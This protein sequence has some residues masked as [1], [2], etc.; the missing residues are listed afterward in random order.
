MPE[1]DGVEATAEIRRLKHGAN[2]PII[3]CTAHA[4]ESDAKVSL[5]LS[6]SLHSLPQN[7]LLHSISSFNHLFPFS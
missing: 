7:L 5:S 3:A 4:I 2:I 6:L 1:M